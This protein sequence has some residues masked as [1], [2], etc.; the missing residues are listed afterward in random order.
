MEFIRVTNAEQDVVNT[1]YWDTEYASSGYYYLT[2]N[3]GAFRLFVPQTRQADLKEFSTAQEVIISIGPWPEQHRDTAIE[4]LFE[5]RTDTPYILRFGLEQTDR[6]PDAADQA[7]QWLFTAWTIGLEKV[8]E[9]PAK[10]RFV[11]KIPCMKPW[12]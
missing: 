10:L 9:R 11:Q 8:L 12:S 3:A 4:L 2:I 1:N 7:W 6:L 5:D